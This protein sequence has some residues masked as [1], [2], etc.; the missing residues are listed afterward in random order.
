[1]KHIRHCRII[2]AFAASSAIQAA[3]AAGLPS[4]GLQAHFRADHTDAIKASTGFLHQGATVTNWITESDVGLSLSLVQHESSGCPHWQTNAF[5]RSDGVPRPA[6]RFRRNSDNTAD[7]ATTCRLVS[8]V[9]TS[10]NM[11]SASTWFLVMN[12]LAENKQSAVF[13]FA[14]GEAAGTTNRFG[15]FFIGSGPLRLHNNSNPGNSGNINVAGGSSNLIDS[16]GDGGRMTS[17]LNGSEQVNIA[18]TAYDRPGDQALYLGRFPGVDDS[19][20][21]DCAELAIYNRALNDAEMR[22]ARNAL[23][24]RWGLSIQDSLWAGAALGFCEDLA[25]IGSATSTGNGRM[26]GV[27]EQ[28]E[29]TGGLFLS[30]PEDSLAGQDGY[31]L[32]AN[33]GNAAKLLLDGGSSLLARVWRVESTLS[34]VPPVTFAFDLSDLGFLPDGFTGRLYRRADGNSSFVDTGVSGTLSN[35]VYLFTF[36]AGAEIAGEFALSVGDDATAIPCAGVAGNLQSWFRAD[37]GVA[38]AS[39][40]VSKWRNL[41]LTGDAGDLAEVTGSPEISTTA[42]S[43]KSV[44]FDGSAVLSTSGN[45]KWGVTM[46]NTWFAVFKVPVANLQNVGVF[47]SSDPTIRFGAFFTGSSDLRGHAYVL[48]DLKEVCVVGGADVKDIQALL[49][50]KDPAMTQRIYVGISLKTQRQTA[51]GIESVLR[52]KV[53][54]A[55]AE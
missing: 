44:H 15:A 5:T 53:E 35:G 51:E 45:T 10:V 2:L 54:K 13:G 7:V 19:A 36:A 4:N 42:F 17:G 31:I 49:G 9:R 3:F 20:A 40:V 24:V 16:R 50:H 1:M 14:G 43:E 8:S 27:V 25:G 12:N 18:Q 41:G 26:P 55:K 33:N 23:A 32:V 48:N 37:T 34:S 52:P 30:V 46:D 38:T 22:I 21:F 39:G 6:V 11:E 29:K 28:S 47:G